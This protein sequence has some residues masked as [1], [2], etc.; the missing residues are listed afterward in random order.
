MSSGSPFDLC[1]SPSGRLPS[2]S[3]KSSS[4]SRRDSTMRP[5]RCAMLSMWLSEKI[6][7]I[8]R[9]NSTIEIT[10]QTVEN[11]LYVQNFSFIQRH[12]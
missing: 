7:S 3:M 4:N 6:S 12:S 9:R 5:V 2:V 1:D 8:D 10:K 11:P